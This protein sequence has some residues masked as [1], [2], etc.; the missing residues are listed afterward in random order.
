LRVPVRG[1]FSIG[2]PAKALPVPPQ[3]GA[4]NTANA[5]N[6]N[7]KRLTIVKPPFMIFGYNLLKN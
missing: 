4:A 2:S 1:S 7:R 5:K 3:N 6:H